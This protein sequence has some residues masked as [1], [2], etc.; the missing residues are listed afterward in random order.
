MLL[1]DFV[2]SQDKGYFIDK[3]NQLF[4][5]DNVQFRNY[6]GVDVNKEGLS[7]DLMVNKDLNQSSGGL[8]VCKDVDNNE[9]CNKKVLNWSGAAINVTDSD[10][11][12]AQINQIGGNLTVP[13]DT[14]M[15]GP[16]KLGACVGVGKTC[17]SPKGLDATTMNVDSFSPL[18]SNLLTITTGSE[19]K[20]INLGPESNLKLQKVCYFQ[21]TGTSP[22]EGVGNYWTSGC[23][24][25]DGDSESG[26]LNNG[27]IK[28]QAGD[29]KNKNSYTN[30]S[31]FGTKPYSIQYPACTTIT[32]A[33]C[34]GYCTAGLNNCIVYN[35]D[36]LYDCKK[37]Y[38]PF[39]VYQIALDDAEDYI[40]PILE[41]SKLPN[42]DGTACT[43]EAIIKN[44]EN[45]ITTT[46]S[47]CRARAAQC[48]TNFDYVLTGI[49]SNT[50]TYI[51]CNVDTNKIRQL[52]YQ[53]TFTFNC[54]KKNPGIRRGSKLCCH[55]SVE[56]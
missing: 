41:S 37:I 17:T 18:D 10:F 25:C 28:T 51:N 30:G 40:K 27:V 53:R 19:Y 26:F 48:F 54:A 50:R 1:A 55:L 6:L 52:F 56:Y 12:R 29:Y 42:D 11:Y 36:F 21:D 34:S 33:K 45:L 4:F 14:T 49:V 35:G 46:L 9:N 24:S 31:G 3:N 23:G 7:G 44:I 20:S 38:M 15:S 43:N 5:Y 16:V 13:G 2:F 8:Y 47:T 22:G 39:G 32:D